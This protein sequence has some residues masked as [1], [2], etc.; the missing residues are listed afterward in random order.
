M[1]RAWFLLGGTLLNFVDYH[2]P[3]WRLGAL[4]RIVFG[5]NIEGHNGIHAIKFLQFFH[6]DRN[7]TD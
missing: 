1:I 3:A 4:G 5:V 7:R 2:L 6:I